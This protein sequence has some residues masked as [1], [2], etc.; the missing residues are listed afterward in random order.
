MDNY[1]IKSTSAYSGQL[2]APIVVEESSTTRKVLY[3]DLNDKKVGVGETV[4]IKIVH[5]RRRQN[6][7]W[8]DVASVNLNSLKGGEGVKL[9]LSSKTTRKIKEKAVRVVD[10]ERTMM[11]WHLGKRILEEEQQGKE[12]ADYAAY[13]TTYIASKLEPEYGSGFSKRQVELFR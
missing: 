11:Y 8:E 13:L 9:D 10:H 5:Q 1:N 6:D 2:M 7:E 3:V 12:R 4:G